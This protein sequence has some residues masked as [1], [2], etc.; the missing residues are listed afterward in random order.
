[1]APAP[2]PPTAH[3]VA[4]SE[5]QSLMQ[6]WLKAKGYLA[7]ANTDDPISRE[8]EQD[9][10]ETKSE[11]SKCQRLLGPKL[12]KEV[13]YGADKMQE[14]LRQSISIGHLRGLPKQDKAT[15][16]GTWHLVFI[17]LS[18]AVGALQFLAEGYIPGE[19]VKAAGSN[20][21]DLKKGSGGPQAA[22]KKSLLKSGKFWVVVIIIVVAVVLVMSKG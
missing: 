18:R 1:M 22:E 14:I 2:K 10:L 21:S 16:M 12:P 17:N 6:L 13:S 19:R 5:A 20:L 4:L 9:F 15:L 11:L 8:H 7:R 3:E